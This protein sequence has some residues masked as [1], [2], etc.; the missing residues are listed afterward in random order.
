M[1]TFVEPLG[2][3]CRRC[4]EA[5]GH[6]CRIF[7]LRID[8][9]EAGLAACRAFDPDLVG[10]QCNF[11]TERRRALR[12]A[13]RLRRELART[14]LVLGGHD[15]SRASS[16]FADPAFDAIAVGDGERPPPLAEAWRA[17]DPAG[18]GAGANRTA[19]RSPLVSP[20]AR[21]SI[22]WRCRRAT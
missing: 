9:V 14:Y 19:D 20:R 7:D 3:L 4:L 5:G 22:P 11:T 6:E 12:L 10:L 21:I 18:S 2:L 15:A 1:L 17:G 8:G 16:W 13:E